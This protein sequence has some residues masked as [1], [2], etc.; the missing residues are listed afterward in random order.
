MK[1]RLLALF[2]AL[3]LLLASGCRAAPARTPD[4]LIGTWKDSYGLTQ[5]RFDEDGSMRIEALNLGNFKGTYS[6]NGDKITIEYKVVV[7]QVKN[8][9]TFRIDGNT[10]YLD[11]NPFTRKK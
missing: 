4:S 11:N 8:T 1:R 7:K 3:I 9:Y 6:V 2:L 10:L 5:Y